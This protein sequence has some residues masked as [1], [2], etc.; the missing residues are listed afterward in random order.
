MCHEY[1][2]RV[3]DRAPTTEEDESEDDIPEF[4]NEEGSDDVEVL[5]DGGDDS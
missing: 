2:S 5:T 4:A 1:Q 3:W